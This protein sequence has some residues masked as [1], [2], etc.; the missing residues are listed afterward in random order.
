MNSKRYEYTNEKVY[1]KPYC[2]VKCLESVSDPPFPTIQKIS[3]VKAS[4][5]VMKVTSIQWKLS[6][7]SSCFCLWKTIL[8]SRT[9]SLVVIYIYIYIYIKTLAYI[10]V[11]TLLQTTKLAI[12]ANMPRIK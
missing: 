7:M 1:F 12:I 2:N 5:E 11:I 10:S 9:R 6:V 4:A 8:Y 3:F